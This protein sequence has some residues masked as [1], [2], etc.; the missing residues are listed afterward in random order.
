M[1]VR[2]NNNNNHARYAAPEDEGVYCNYNQHYAAVAPMSYETGTGFSI[3]PDGAIGFAH[4]IENKLSA[5]S[6]SAEASNAAKNGVSNAA[7]DAGTTNKLAATIK[8]NR[9]AF[10]RM[11]I[12]CESIVVPGGANGY[13]DEDC[14][15]DEVEEGGMVHTGPQIKPNLR[16]S[17]ENR[18]NEDKKRKSARKT[19]HDILH[20]VHGKGVGEKEDVQEG[21]DSDSDGEKHDAEDSNGTHHAHQQMQLAGK[22]SSKP[23]LQMKAKSTKSQASFPS[24]FATGGI[25][26]YEDAHGLECEDEEEGDSALGHPTLFAHFDCDDDCTQGMFSTGG[27]IMMTGAAAATIPWL[28]P[29]AAMAMKGLA[30]FDNPKEERFKKMIQNAN[31]EEKKA[32]ATLVQNARTA[33]AKVFIKKAYYQ[34]VNENKQPGEKRTPVMNIFA[35][36]DTA[37]YWGGK[38][39]AIMQKCMS[40]VGAHVA[41]VLSRWHQV[42]VDYKALV[43]HRR[44]HDYVATLPPSNQDAFKS[45]LTEYSN[46][47][48]IIRGFIDGNESSPL[49]ARR[50]FESERTFFSDKHVRRLLNNVK[51]KHYLHTSARLGGSDQTTLTTESMVTG[52]DETLDC[53]CKE[54][55]PMSMQ[56]YA[57]YTGSRFPGEGLDDNML[58][59]VATG[60]KHSGKLSEGDKRAIGA[61]KGSLAK[62]RQDGNGKQ[63]PQGKK[64]KKQGQAASH[65]HQAHPGPSQ[66]VYHTVQPHP[67]P[68]HYSPYPHQHQAAW[69]TPVTHN[70]NQG[71]GRRSM[72]QPQGRRGGK[73]MSGRRSGKPAFHNGVMNLQGFKPRFRHAEIPDESMFPMGAPM[74]AAVDGY[75]MYPYAMGY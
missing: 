67:Q 25:Y 55:T 27:E 28:D 3:T 68:V 41:S 5:M 8:S 10:E 59:T 24:P 57:Q 15:D 44:V 31:E 17:G 51:V 69:V 36:Y 11:E 4:D 2:R 37:R 43:H 33:L 56:E 32:Y 66:H 9:D 58:P 48:R 46:T 13:D 1:S 12:T 50:L 75:P 60:V 19:K 61:I 74:P 45:V 53:Y 63:K 34:K 38:G 70:G 7:A 30:K 40:E 16:A 65:Q 73:P 35:A 22:K 49:K 14:F 47:E 23:H 52:L 18:E 21:Q 39:N 64:G 72:V 29:L 71:Q 6:L 42:G 26:D 54:P 62:Q 20:G